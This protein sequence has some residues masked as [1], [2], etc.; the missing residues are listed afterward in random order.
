MV[1]AV[2]QAT[3][4]LRCAFNLAA[5]H[6]ASGG[7][8]GSVALWVTSAVHRRGELGYVF[9]PR[10]WSHGYATEA[11]VALL[12]FGFTTL[13]LHRIAATCDPANVASVRV[14][15]KCGMDY[16]G[17]LRDHLSVRGGWRDSLLYAAV[18]RPA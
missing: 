12:E 5:V 13:S 18:G 1:N 2:A 11:T 3:D 9:H 7:V 17:R 6:S 16:E 10:C 15:E 8:I 14:L 4:P